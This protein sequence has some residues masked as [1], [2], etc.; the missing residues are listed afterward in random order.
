MNKKDADKIARMHRLI[1][2]FVVCILHKRVIINSSLNS[3][4][5]FSSQNLPRYWE[6]KEYE[7]FKFEKV[8]CIYSMIYCNIK[9]YILQQNLYFAL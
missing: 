2:V 5:E 7:I 1:C 4:C 3:N 9:G 6:Q 8:S